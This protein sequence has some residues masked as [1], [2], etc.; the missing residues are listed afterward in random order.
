MVL[1]F[2]VKQFL[3]PFIQRWRIEEGKQF[4]YFLKG[5]R[6]QMVKITISCAEIHSV[7]NTVFGLSNTV[8]NRFICELTILNISVFSSQ[9]YTYFLI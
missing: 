6:L 7:Q 1:R 5:K 3:Y 2:C 8:S 4:V 9:K